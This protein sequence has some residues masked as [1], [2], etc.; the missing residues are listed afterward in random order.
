M[1]FIFKNVFCVKSCPSW[2]M[3]LILELCVEH[4]KS[5]SFCLLIWWCNQLTVSTTRLLF[6]LK[7]NI[8]VRTV[9]HFGQY[10]MKHDQLYK[11]CKGEI[12]NRLICIKCFYGH[13]TKLS[14]PYSFTLVGNSV[15]PQQT[16]IQ[17]FFLNAFRYWADFWYV[18]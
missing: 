10:Q 2:Q 15:I 16:I 1:V 13:A 17:S 8:S 3:N 7:T 12:F 6:Y 4:I 9:E 14:V 18:S 5:V 11:K